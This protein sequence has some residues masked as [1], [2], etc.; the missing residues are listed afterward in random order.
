L[1]TQL[2]G[3]PLGRV[4]HESFAFSADGR[5]L[6]AGFI[7]P[8]EA[9]GQTFFR[10]WDTADVSRPVASFTVPFVSSAPPAVSND[11]RRVFAT[12]SEGGHAYDASSGRELSAMT[13]TG[14]A[15]FALSP[16][17]SRLAIRDGSQIRFLDPER[18]TTLSVMSE[19][20][21]I[22][23]ALAFAP[24]GKRVAY[25][26]DGTTVVRAVDHQDRP[27]A[28]YP[29]GDEK[30]PSALLFGRGGT[31]LYGAR[32]D[33]LL[34]AWDLKGDRRY[35]PASASVK[36]DLAGDPYLS[37]MSPDN[38][39]VAHFVRTDQGPAVQ[40]RDVQSGNLGPPVP[41]GQTE[42]WFVNFVWRPDSQAV[43]S[44]LDDEWV[45]VWARDS[46]RLLEQH[47]TPGDGV[48]SVAFSRDGSR[49][50]IG[51][52]NGW[53]KTFDGGERTAG[54]SIRISKGPV[55]SVAVSQ[56]GRR[57]VAVA[58]QEGILLDLSSGAVLRRVNLSF[59]GTEGL[60]WAPDGRT[61]A[62]TG[63]A[64]SRALFGATAVLD[65]KTLAEV[66]VV[67]GPRAGGGYPTYSPDGERFMTVGDEQ[68]RI[69]DGHSGRVVESL[70]SESLAAA[71]FGTDS[72]TVTLVSATGGISYWDSRPEAALKAACRMVGRDLTDEEWRT[73]LPNRARMRVC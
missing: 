14:P 3:M 69:F 21:R 26:V 68:V 33:G 27:G 70:R 72:W 45:R 41:T 20:G 25:V 15:G 6:A 59:A 35:V 61:I 57:A 65:A 54:T 1:P 37:A 40:F 11:G 51:T 56:D 42:G 5:W 9:D 19:E 12:S 34:L 48:F 13:A 4:L 52:R 28:R 60:T 43:A 66:S 67:V 29:T 73:Y 38:K 32:T 18:L 36:H 39:T 71:A 7:H 22:E 8:R 2:G 58:A 63:V 10:L 44:V 17:G 23:D 62:A 50:A 30:G 46:G 31:T 53:V 16:D 47:R 24:D 49:L 55:S 64:P